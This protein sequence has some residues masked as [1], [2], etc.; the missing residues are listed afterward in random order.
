[1]TIYYELMKMYVY[2]FPFAYSN[3]QNSDHVKLD[4]IIL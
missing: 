2:T 4:I 3:Q 1:M